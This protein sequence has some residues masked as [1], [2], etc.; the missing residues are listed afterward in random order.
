MARDEA[1]A[2]AR[3]MLAGSAVPPTTRTKVLPVFARHAAAAFH[4]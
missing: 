4:A 2:T 1:P 3:R